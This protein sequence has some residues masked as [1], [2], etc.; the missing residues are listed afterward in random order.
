MC[1]ESGNLS[2][3][4]PGPSKVWE[5]ATQPLDPQSST[6]EV[7]KPMIAT[8]HRGRLPFPIHCPADTHPLALA[9]SWPITLPVIPGGEEPH[10]ITT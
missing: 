6:K 2:S 3:S 4:T 9:W 10:S 7:Q 5:H 8:Y 1:L